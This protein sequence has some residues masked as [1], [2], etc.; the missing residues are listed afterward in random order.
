[1]PKVQGFA[2]CVFIAHSHREFLPKGSVVYD[3]SSYAEPP[4]CTLSPMM[5][6]VTSDTVE[7]IWQG[8]KV[9]RGEI[10]TRYFVGRGQK[11]GGKPAGH[12]WG[13]KLLKIVEARERIYRPSYEWILNNRVDPSLIQ[14]FISSA[15]EGTTQY[16][17]DVS[18]NGDISNP[19]E[20]WAHAAVLVQFL[21]R[22]CTERVSSQKR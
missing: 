3:V 16:F 1:M 5:P 11:R 20:G 13:R 9:I 15:L 17:H 18:D 21:N 10:A 4:Y 19:D 6:R 2:R 7:G 12:Q 14:G 8:L 22:V